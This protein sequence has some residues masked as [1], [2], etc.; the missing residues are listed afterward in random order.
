MLTITSL[1][2]LSVLI[3]ETSGIMQW[4]KYRYD[5]HDLRPLDCPMCL[6]WWMSLTYFLWLQPDITAPLHAA[7]ASIL[8]IFISR[9]L[10]R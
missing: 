7:T 10:R 2:C 4:I 3:S 9:E 1:A 5:L 6:A 8:A